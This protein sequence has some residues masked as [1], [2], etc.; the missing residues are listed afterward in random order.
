MLKLTISDAN[1]WKRSVDAIAALIDEGTFEFEEKGMALKAMD[2]SQIAMVDFE[3]PK[4]AFKDYSSSAKQSMGIDFSELSRVMRRARAEDV[5]KME[6]KGNKLDVHFDGKTSRKFVL[7]LI[8]ATAHPNKPKIEFDALVKISAN[9]LKEVLADVELVSNY[10]VLDAA[11][12]E[13][14]IT[15]ESESGKAEIKFPQKALMEL[16]VKAA[17]RAMFPLEYL[18][19]MTRNTDVTTVVNLSIKKDAPLMLDYAIGESKI[20]YFLAP[21]IENV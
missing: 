15:S 17:S 10:V 20:T 12:K 4:G 2:P 3:M 13:L 21:R 19:N 14:V 18:K 16:K 11:E 5:I 8:D 7:P 6:L 9:D 1:A